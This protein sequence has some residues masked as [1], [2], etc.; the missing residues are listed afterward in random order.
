MWVLGL[1]RERIVKAVLDTFLLFFPNN[2]PPTSTMYLSPY[3]LVDIK[4]RASKAL[5]RLTVSSLEWVDPLDSHNIATEPSHVFVVPL[6]LTAADM[7]H[8]HT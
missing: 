2:P 1:M 3:Y 7:A 6:A 8:P 4:K 5:C